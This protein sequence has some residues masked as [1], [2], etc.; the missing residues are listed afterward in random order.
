MTVCGAPAIFSAITMSDFTIAA[1]TIQRR[2]M[3]RCCAW[4]ND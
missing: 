4:I 3:T 1:K 2:K